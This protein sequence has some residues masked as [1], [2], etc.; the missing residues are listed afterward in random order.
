M[1]NMYKIL[2]KLNSV[3]ASNQ[4]GTSNV[5]SN[6]ASNTSATIS[7]SA[8]NNTNSNDQVNT[9][10]LNTLNSHFFNKSL[11]KEKK[12]ALSSLQ[13]NYQVTLGGSGGGPS[14]PSRFPFLNRALEDYSQDE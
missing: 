14:K 11:F 13:K 4:D 5:T 9:Q 12:P 3:V 10:L 8:Q 1:D 7:N 2:K 6:A